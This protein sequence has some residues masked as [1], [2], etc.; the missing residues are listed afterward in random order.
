M[1]WLATYCSKLTGVSKNSGDY[2]IYWW[3]SKPLLYSAVL[4]QKCNIIVCLLTM[5]RTKPQLKPL[6]NLKDYK[7]ASPVR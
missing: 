5:L 1:H 7:F 3:A 4:W 2:K 6:L